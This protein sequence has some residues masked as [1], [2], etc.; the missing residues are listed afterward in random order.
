MTQRKEPDGDG[1]SE[2]ASGFSDFNPFQSSPDEEAKSKRRRK[3][4]MGVK[5]EAF[6]DPSSVKRSKTLSDISHLAADQGTPIPNVREE[7]RISAPPLPSD[8]LQRFKKRIS[9]TPDNL[10]SPIRRHLSPSGVSESKTR[11]SFASLA[12]APEN[13][14]VKA[15]TSPR[16]SEHSRPRSPEKV[17]GIVREQQPSPAVQP[18]PPTNV[19][20]DDIYQSQTDPA[21]NEDE[22]PEVLASSSS[23]QL[24][25]DTSRSLVRTESPGRKKAS[26][27]SDTNTGVTTSGNTDKSVTRSSGDVGR[28]GL[29]VSGLATSLLF[30]ALIW[31]SASVWADEKRALGFC[32]T[33]EDINEAVVKR[34]DQSA[35]VRHR[36]LDLH[37]WQDYIDHA[38]DFVAP[39]TCTP[40]PEQAEC[41]GGQLKACSQGYI[42]RA[43]PLAAVL[44]GRQNA[45]DV[46]RSVLPLVLP[47]RCVPD[48]AYLH[49]VLEI[50]AASS[51]HLRHIKGDILCTGQSSR[52]GREAKKLLIEGPKDAYVYGTQETQL[53]Q[54][55]QSHLEVCG[56]LKLATSPAYARFSQVDAGEIDFQRKFT[57]ALGYLSNH[58]EIISATFE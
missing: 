6:A 29:Q 11:P 8:G 20:E 4:S 24:Q 53:K 14:E 51:A 52:R 58:T 43:N 48:T 39:L 37:N 42:Q 5:R 49:R 55:V 30:L 50:A 56:L 46:N 38:R 31:Q 19:G 41:S 9:S 2:A 36:N 18:S 34:Q 16:K 33:G 7:S 54:F 35:L 10:P 44:S 17:G 45:L 15:Y 22:G 27:P 1:K 47:P 23:S 26:A 40:C 57:E 25:E 13:F 12:T 32:D 21:S 28:K 3:S